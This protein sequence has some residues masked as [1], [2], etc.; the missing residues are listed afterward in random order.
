M[1]AVVMILVVAVIMA[2]VVVMVMALVIAVIMVVVRARPTAAGRGRK[3][4]SV[5]LGSE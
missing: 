1:P 5:S 4:Y 2:F 3:V